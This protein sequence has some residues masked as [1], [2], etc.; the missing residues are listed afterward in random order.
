MPYNLG[1][2]DH[3]RHVTFVDDDAFIKYA[4]ENLPQVE[5]EDD[6]KMMLDMAYDEYMGLVQYNNVLLQTQP[7]A[8]MRL[9][10]EERFFPISREKERFAQF[11]RMRLGELVPGLTLEQFMQMSP[12]HTEWLFEA[13]AQAPK[14]TLEK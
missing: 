5:K 13:I 7:L 10:P 8:T 6:A 9:W 2:G 12:E 4:F 14:N 1:F 3:P 11:V